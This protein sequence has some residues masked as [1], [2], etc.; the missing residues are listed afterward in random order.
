MDL[1]LLLAAN[2]AVI[3]GAV[4]Q[5]ATGLGAGL[6]IVPLLALV[7]LHYV[8]GPMIFASL[9]L[10]IT[11]T[12]AGWRHID[13]RHLGVLTLG[14]V[15]GSAIGAI[16]LLGIPLQ[17]LGLVFGVLV[18]LAVILSLSGLKPRFTRPHLLATGAVSGFMGTTAA[19]GAPVLALLYQHKKGPALR[20]TLALLYVISA[21]MM[22]LLLH[23]VGRFGR[24]E[25]NAGF[26]LMP[27]FIIGY[28][29]GQ[30][31]ARQID[32]G[33]SRVAVLVISSVSA[34]LLIAKS[35]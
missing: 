6:I 30:P 8:P 18:L 35:L 17:R 22:V 13:R 32:R 10:S 9:A 11:M 29:L 26:N 5:A 7:S 1:L 28:F 23:L 19:M 25:L 27:G 3:L 2:A 16:S 31:F 33:R 20:A 14:L 24:Y 12:V 4:L 21:L 34:L 15:A